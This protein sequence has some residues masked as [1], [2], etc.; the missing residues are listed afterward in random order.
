[1]DGIEIE[2]LRAC[3][4][5]GLEHLMR[6]ADRPVIG[7]YLPPPILMPYPQLERRAPL[8]EELELIDAEA[9]EED[10]ERRGRRLAHANGRN[11]AGLDHGDAGIEP[12]PPDG[13]LHDEG[14]DP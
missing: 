12:H 8:L 13:V 6:I 1:R 3:A 9:F 4:G 7:E 10:V 14:S 2:V 5:R 11:L